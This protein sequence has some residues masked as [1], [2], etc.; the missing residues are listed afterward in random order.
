MT[1]RLTQEAALAMAREIAAHIADSDG[2]TALA[3]DIRGGFHDDATEVNA[4]LEAICAIEDRHEAEIA[5]KDATIKTLYDDRDGEREF[6]ASL[7]AENARLR[8]VQS[9][10]DYAIGNWQKL[11]NGGVCRD[12]L[13]CIASY[14]YA[15]AALTDTGALLDTHVVTPETPDERTARMKADMDLRLTDLVVLE[16]VCRPQRG[17]YKVA[18]GVVLTAAYP[19]LIALAERPTI[20]APMWWRR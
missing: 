17:S 20:P 16:S 2:A 14:Q 1:E 11:I 15:R 10:A 19:P 3:A 7:R 12:V 4:A 8:A 6:I 18:T 9:A 13:E 5:A